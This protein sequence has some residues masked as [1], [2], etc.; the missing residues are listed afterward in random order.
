ML[1]VRKR[2]R[3]LIIRT[4]RLMAERCRLLSR[5]ENGGSVVVLFTELRAV[6]FIF[7]SR[8]YLNT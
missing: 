4:L 5:F 1:I 3:K 6:V 8:T 2:Q 7:A